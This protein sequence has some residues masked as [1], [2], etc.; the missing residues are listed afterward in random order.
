MNVNQGCRAI[1]KMTQLWL[2]STY[3]REHG[4]GSSAL[5]FH[6]PGSGSGAPFF[7]AA[8]FVRFHILIVSIALVCLKLNGK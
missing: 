6:E 1:I 8:A 2:Q 7:M 3:F 5:G 4:S